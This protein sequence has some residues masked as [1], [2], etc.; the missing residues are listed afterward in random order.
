MATQPRIERPQDRTHTRDDLGAIVSALAAAL[1]GIEILDRALE[2]DD[3]A[4]AE[5][6]GVDASG[7]LVLVQVARANGEQAALDAL[8]LFALARSTPELFARHL[9]TEKLVPELG[10]RVVVIAETADARLAQRLAALADLGL[11]LCELR[12]VKSAAGEHIYL[13]PRTA[14]AGLAAAAPARS[15]ESF[16][17]GVPDERRELGRSLCDRLARLDDE[18]RLEVGPESAGWHF[19]E[20]LLV[21]LE[22]RGGRLL[23][24][25]GPRGALR[26]LESPRDADEL[27]EEALAR[28]VD[29]VGPGASDGGAEGARREPI[30]LLSPEELEAFRD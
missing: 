27:L 15:L 5:L 7:R 25:V 11:V 4:R 8:D 13:L 23:G 18:L 24:A 6:A 29:G 20:R 9:A 30:A 12:S 3:G 26:A 19:Q 10:V 1:P 17:E 16:L 21:R 22:S 2:F 28:L 14:V